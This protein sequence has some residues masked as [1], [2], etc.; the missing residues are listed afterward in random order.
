ML[1]CVKYTSI[2]VRTQRYNFSRVRAKEK[3]S[4]SVTP[5][6]PSTRHHSARARKLNTRRRGRVRCETAIEGLGGKFHRLSTKTALLA[7]I[8]TLTL[9]IERILPLLVL[10]NLP[11]LVVPAVLV[12]AVGLDLL[13]EVNHLHKHWRQ[14]PPRRTR[15]HRL[16]KSVTTHKM[17]SCGSI[18]VRNPT[19]HNAE[20]RGGKRMLSTSVSPL[21]PRYTNAHATSPHCQEKHLAAV[22][23]PPI[24]HHTRESESRSPAA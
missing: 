2:H 17:L 24:K 18:T 23:P 9:S 20:P 10:S 14:N 1:N 5:S 16:S 15:T 12:L 7:V 19:E 4:A 6:S 11:L 22:A 21:F 3:V 13:G 8:T